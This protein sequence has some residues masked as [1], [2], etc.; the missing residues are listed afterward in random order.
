MRILIF[1]IVAFY[2]CLSTECISKDTTY[3]RYYELVNQAEHLFFIE[4]EVDSA[5]CR[6]DKAFEEY[7]YVF[8]KDLLNAAQI[9]IFSQKAYKKYLSRGFGLGLTFEHLRQ[10]SLIND[11]IPALKSDRDFMNSIANKRQSYV[12]S[13]DFE[14]LLKIYDLGITDQIEK[15]KPADIYSKFKLKSIEQIKLIIE[16]KGFPGTKVLGI[17]SKTIFSEIDKPLYDIDLRKSKY[18][19]KLSYY[20]TQDNSFASTMVF[21]VLIH[22]QCAFIE[23]ED[24]LYD[25]MLRGEIHP[26]EIGLLYDNM[27]RNV[28]KQD[29][30]CEQIPP[31]Q[32]G[33][34]RL[35]MFLKDKE[36][37]IS[38][39]LTNEIRSKWH[40]V[41]LEVDKQKK[42]YEKEYGF[43]L[44]HG[45]WKCL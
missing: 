38:N 29:Y 40:I 12:K 26:R 14:S 37:N 11:F 34:F 44:F 41:N 24:I 23:L 33:V 45:F 39:E 42:R 7:D 25:A 20:S 36:L 28:N 43:K 16:N 17:D 19:N 18:S 1:I 21:K 32:N 35:N 8:L 27:F 13:I 5:L 2:M 22:N 30:R 3:L 4:N 31:V 10:F 6:Y 15:N 9:S